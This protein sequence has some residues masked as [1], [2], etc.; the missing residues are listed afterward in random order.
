M[1]SIEK[2]VVCYGGIVALREVSIEVKEGETVLLVGANGAGKSSLINAVVGLVP[3]ASGQ[4]RF[5][6][7]DLVGVSC[8]A[9]ARLGIGYSPEGRRIFRSL[10][11]RENV[12]A[13]TLGI[14]K[15]TAQANL[16]WM[17]RTF[18]LL[19]E[20]A[21]QPANQ[22]SGGQQQVVA[23]ARAA[24]TL[25]KL[26]L[27]D[28]PFLGLAPVWIERISD[29]IRELQR[30]GTTILMTEQMARPALKLV[31]RAYVMRGGEVRRSGTVD[32]IRDVALADE[33]L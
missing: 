6:G 16:E 9:R 11:V 29:S 13:G 21:D 33:Y 14:A 20:R 32:E 5:A 1:L 8:P 10:T 23:L 27:L 4:I 3:A 17:E 24:S 31:D 18:P 12:L 22:L 28:E 25:P 15:A 19:A 7:K 30:R 26:L 2:L